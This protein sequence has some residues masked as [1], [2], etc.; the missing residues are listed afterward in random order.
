MPKS[1]TRR[2]AERFGFDPDPRRRPETGL[3]RQTAPAVH[4]YLHTARA[5]ETFERL[6]AAGV[7]LTSSE[8]PAEGPAREAAEPHPELTGKRIVLT[9]TLETSTRPA[10]T[11]KLESLGA[12]VTG[13]VSRHTDLLIAGTKAGS[14]L[15]QARRLGVEIWDEARLIEAIGPPA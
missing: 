12:K 8:A 3:G 5:K 9:G 4:A 10:L 1:L 15:E 11:E 13:S 7:D 6:A 14:K 2:E